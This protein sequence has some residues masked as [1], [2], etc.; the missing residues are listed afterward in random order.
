MQ[1]ALTSQPDAST[2]ANKDKGDIIGNIK[3]KIGED[4]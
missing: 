1:R 2:N 4:I 3:I